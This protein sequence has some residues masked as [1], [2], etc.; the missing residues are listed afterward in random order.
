MTFLLVTGTR[1]ATIAD[2]GHL[3]CTAIRDLAGQV[4]TDPHRIY[5]GD[6]ESGVDLI[7]RQGFTNRPGWDVKVFEAYWE[8]CGPGCPSGNHR[9]FR[10]TR[11]PFAGPRRNRRMAKQFAA[12]GGRIGLAFPERGHGFAR[13]GTWGCTLEATELGVRM[14][15]ESLAVNRRG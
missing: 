5:V 11:C 10:G 7:V 3:V 12:D 4:V 14:T 15:V 6:C 2:H 9:T 8:E 1:H 13:S